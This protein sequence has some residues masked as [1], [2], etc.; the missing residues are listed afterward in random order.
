MASAW[1]DSWGDA[2]G[3]SWGDIVEIPEDSQFFFD[4][5]TGIL[6][7]IFVDILE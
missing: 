5:A 7:N 2:W 3:N 1:G 6:S 4:V